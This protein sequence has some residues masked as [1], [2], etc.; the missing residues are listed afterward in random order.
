MAQDKSLLGPTG[1]SY[2]IRDQVIATDLDTHLQK[3]ARL[4]GDNHCGPCLIINVKAGCLPQDAEVA[5][6]LSTW[7][8][9]DDV[10]SVSFARTLM[11]FLAIPQEIDRQEPHGEVV[12]HY[13]DLS[14]YQ[15]LRSLGAQ[16]LITVDLPIRGARST[17]L[18]SGPYHR[19]KAKLYRVGRQYEDSQSA[20]F[21]SITQNTDRVQTTFSETR[22]ASYISVPSR[23]Y[24][25]PPSPE[26]PLSGFR[27]GA[28]DVFDVAGLRTSAGSSDFYS[29]HSTKERTSEAIADLLALGAILVGKTKNTQFVNGEDP[30]EWIDYSCPWNPRGSTVLSI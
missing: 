10:I 25:P 4:L 8:Q 15:Y 18:A 30:Q 27:F 11:I 13:R 29:F 1:A 7:L 5:H 22:P 19:E 16:A 26:L 14:G 28:K 20:F 6:L 9:E 2:N 12:V 24:Y 21:S 3:I 17:I 23:L